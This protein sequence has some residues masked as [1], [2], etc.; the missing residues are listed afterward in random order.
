MRRLILF[1]GVLVTGVLSQGFLQPPPFR[2]VSK[3]QSGCGGIGNGRVLSPFLKCCPVVSS[4]VGPKPVLPD[5]KQHRQLHRERQTHQSVVQM[6]PKFIHRMRFPIRGKRQAGRRPLPTQQRRRRRRCWGGWR[7]LWRRWQ[8][9]NT[10]FICD[11]VR[12]NK[13]RYW[14][15]ARE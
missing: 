8:K 13:I 3:A 7:R 10:Y 5:K 2:P 12:F 11:T 15:S 9:I 14:G 4:V 1:V 6:K